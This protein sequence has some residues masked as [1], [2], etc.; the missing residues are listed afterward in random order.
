[1][2]G[3][4]SVRCK[5]VHVTTSLTPKKLAGEVN[6]VLGKKKLFFTFPRNETRIEAKANLKFPILFRYYFS[7]KGNL[8]WRRGSPG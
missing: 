3:F 8:I 4:Q 5:I 6:L 1:M 7:L 2:Q